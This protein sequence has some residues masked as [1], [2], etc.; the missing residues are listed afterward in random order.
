[1]KQYSI[2]EIVTTCLDAGEEKD[3]S[4]PL[5]SWTSAI[6]WMLGRG[7][8]RLSHY[9]HGRVP[10]FGCWGGEGSVSPIIIMDECHCLDA[11]EGKDPSLPLLSWTS[12]IVWM[13]GRGRIRLSHYYHGR[14]PLF[15]C[16]GEEG[17]VSPII[18][19]DEC[20]CLDAGEG[21]DPSLPLL[22]WTSDI[23]SVILAA[24]WEG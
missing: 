17:S 20:H 5:L 10:L 2:S 16:W 8:I 9:Y 13:L 11:G 3:P 21:K 19:M 23:V 4:L 6:V 15:G 24:P 1:M 7:R 18:I 12:A 14:V 22:S